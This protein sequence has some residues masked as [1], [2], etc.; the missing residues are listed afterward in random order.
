MITCMLVAA[1]AGKALGTDMARELAVGHLVAAARQSAAEIRSP[2]LRHLARE[3]ATD[4]GSETRRKQMAAVVFWCD[5]GTED[6]IVGMLEVEET[7]SLVYHLNPAGRIGLRS[8][9]RLMRLSVSMARDDEGAEWGGE[10]VIARHTIIAYLMET[11]AVILRTGAPVYHNKSGLID[12]W[13]VMAAGCK[14]QKVAAELTKAIE[15]LRRSN[16]RRSP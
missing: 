1:L 5:I 7:R 6:V 12:S 11:S 4:L 15:D 14:D 13:A 16:P 9:V 3:M 8:L 10:L 2:E